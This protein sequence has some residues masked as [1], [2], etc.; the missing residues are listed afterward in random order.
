MGPI[1]RVGFYNPMV[2]GWVVT[3]WG[4]G[5]GGQQLMGLKII[6]G[7]V[8]RGQALSLDNLQWWTQKL[9][10]GFIDVLQKTTARSLK[11]FQERN[12]TTSPGLLDSE[13]PPL[14]GSIEQVFI[15][16]RIAT[17]LLSLLPLRNPDLKELVYGLRVALA[18]GQLEQLQNLAPAMDSTILRRIVGLP[19]SVRANFEP[20]SV[21]ASRQGYLLTLG[22][23]NSAR[24]LMIAEVTPRADQ[25]E[26]VFN[27]LTIVDLKEDHNEKPG[28]QE[29]E[30]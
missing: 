24:W 5:Q 8:M 9:S 17:V 29:K 14:Q 10:G 19:S 16:S 21:M 22:L 6:P 30:S 23:S 25:E 11:A 1:I 13:P 4:K 3:E 20:T 15:E 28:T 27:H 12:L 18:S 2:D 26:I 7:E